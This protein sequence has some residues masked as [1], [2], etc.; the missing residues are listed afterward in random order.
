M[1]PADDEVGKAKVGEAFLA[2]SASLGLE[3]L[4]EQG[5]VKLC[6]LQCNDCNQGV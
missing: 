4:C 2:A 1:A 3:E 5:L 6:S